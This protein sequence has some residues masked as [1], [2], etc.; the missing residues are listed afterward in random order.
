MTIRENIGS[1]Q[2]AHDPSLWIRGPFLQREVQ[3]RVLL[4]EAYRSCRAQITA[5][6]RNENARAVF[7]SIVFI[8]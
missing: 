8:I 2:K 4:H 1:I 3:V 7:F 5:A 6:K